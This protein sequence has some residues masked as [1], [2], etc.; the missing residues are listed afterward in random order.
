MVC[1][2]IC[3]KERNVEEEYNMPLII[4]WKGLRNRFQAT[5]RRE[6]TQIYRHAMHTR[7]SFSSNYE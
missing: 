3:E 6:H 2:R 4:E 1:S 5:S 7:F